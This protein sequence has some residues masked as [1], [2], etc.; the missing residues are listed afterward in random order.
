MVK[1]KS[2]NQ[3]RRHF[4]NTIQTSATNHHIP[5]KPRFINM[6]YAHCNAYFW[7]PCH[8]CGQNFGGHESYGSENYKSVCPSCVLKYYNET[9]KFSNDE[10]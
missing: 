2:E 8:K 6:I 4:F 5:F 7:L 1:L 9:G 3:L 10:R